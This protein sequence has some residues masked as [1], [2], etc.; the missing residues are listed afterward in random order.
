M[1]E[2]KRII[3]IAI[4]FFI[5]FSTFYR[6]IAF[7]YDP[8]C[9]NDF[10]CDPDWEAPEYYENGEA[11]SL[12]EEC[13]LYGGDYLVFS[14]YSNGKFKYLYDAEKNE[15]DDSEYN[16]VRH[17]GTCYALLDLYEEVEIDKYLNSGVAGLDYLCEF[18]N[19]IS[20]DKWAIDWGGEMKVGTVSLAIL[21]MVRYY[22]ATD[23][24]KYNIYIE[25]FANF[26]VSQQRDDGAFAG[27]YGDEDEDLYY[28]GE[29][30]FAL[31]L[32]YDIF[33]KNYYLESIE[34]A[35]KYYWSPFYDY[36]NSAFIPWASSGCA[37]W[38]ELTN[39]YKFLEF[40]FEMTDIQIS[41]QNYENLCDELG[42]NLYGY[43][44]GP[45]VNTGVYLEGIGDAFRI[46]KSVYDSQRIANYYKSLKAGLEWLLSLQ[47][48][49]ESQLTC[50]NRGY[51]GFHEGFTIDD[52]YIVRIDYNQHAISA[53]LR[54]LRE[55]SDAEI[56]SVQILDG[57]VD[58]DSK[59]VKTMDPLIENLPLIFSFVIIPL[60]IIYIYMRKNLFGKDL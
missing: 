15:Y 8:F 10:S 35:L 5:V 59:K 58:F 3:V 46:A 51:G 39:D 12:V 48:R 22:E 20:K 2:K 1:A 31:S 28:S 38:F 11:E 23:R 42:N 33:E 32:A 40:C 24:D 45:T 30:F 50:P 14:Q 13:A 41:R 49:K 44:I 52:P 56:E 21:G 53:I 18:T 60:I 26:I 57:I 29:A 4:I 19:R 55:F 47:F 54:I 9:F 37:K 6:F 27:I 17:A 7:Y 25:K 43:F 16:I 34:K 36:N